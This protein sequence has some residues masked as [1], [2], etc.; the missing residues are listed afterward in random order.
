[1]HSTYAD[2]WAALEAHALEDRVPAAI[3]GILERGLA[4]ELPETPKPGDPMFDRAHNVVVGSND[5]AARALIRRAEARGL[6]AQLLS[7]F[8]EGEAREVGIVLA[9]MAREVA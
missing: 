9:A 8:V 2:A 3:R 5:I 7:T 1:D 6:N 4:G